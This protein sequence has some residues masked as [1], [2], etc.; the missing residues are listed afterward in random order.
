[1]TDATDAYGVIPEVSYYQSPA[2]GRVAAVTRAEIE[3]AM[4]RQG[5]RRH[6][7]SWPRTRDAIAIGKLAGTYPAAAKETR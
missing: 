5:E 7:W 4:S 6:R 1:M 3:A 2:T